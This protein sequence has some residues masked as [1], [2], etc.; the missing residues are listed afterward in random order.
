MGYLLAPL[1]DAISAAPQL[2]GA[3]CIGMHEVFDPRHH[4]EA[5]QDAAYRHAAGLHLCHTCPAL[6]D[7]QVWFLGLK[8]SRR[9]RG[10]VAGRINE[11]HPRRSKVGAADGLSDSE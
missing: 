7:C 10:V 8:P 5:I 11:P 4:D 9:P 6:A 1:L 2:D 3:Q